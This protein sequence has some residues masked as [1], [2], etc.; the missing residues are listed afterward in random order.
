[1]INLIIDNFKKEKNF[2]I[3]L[4]SSYLKSYSDAKLLITDFSGTAYTFSYS[5]LKPAIFFS[6]NEK[7]LLKSNN[8][9][10]SYFR[11]RKN[12]GEICS[13]VKR[14]KGIISKIEKKDYFYSKKISILRKKRIKHLNNS[15]NKTSELILNL[16]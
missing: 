2:E 13:D 4:S 11:D 7:K 6:K 15:L 3:D 14:L 12:I 10:L 8:K 1:M 16:S 5:T 9:N